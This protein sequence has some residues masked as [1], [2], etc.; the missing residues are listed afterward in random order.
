M[1]G[2]VRVAMCDTHIAV[3]GRSGGEH[4]VGVV[5]LARC[6]FVCFGQPGWL[7]QIRAT[8]EGSLVADFAFVHSANQ[9]EWLDQIKAPG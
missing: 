9:P 7:D 5:C 6:G 3:M 4:S 8:R 2:R 1:D